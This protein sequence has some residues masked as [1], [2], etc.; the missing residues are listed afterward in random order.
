MRNTFMN[1]I[2]GT[3]ME[4]E[5]IY[6]VSG[7]AGLGVFDDFKEKLPD[8]FINMGVAEQNM[9][10]FSAGLAMTGFKV[11]LYN[12]TPFLIYRCYE[13]VRN[14]ICYQ[15]MPVV[16]V[17]IG[18]GLTYAPAG[19][20]HYSVEDIGVAQTL[21]NLIVLSPIDPVE[22]KL[23]AQYS[24]NS[25]APV[26]VRIPKNGEP[27]IHKDDNFDITR[28]CLI[29]DGEDISILFHGSI[30]IEVMKANQLLRKEGIFPRLISVP[31]VQPL[32]AEGLFRMLQ[33]S[34]HVLCVEEHFV[35]TGLGAI[36]T[37]EYIKEK[38]SWDFHLMGITDRFIHEIKDIHGM[39]EFFG[40]S[41]IK[42]SE[43]SK[44]LLC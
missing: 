19:M 17:G 31:M 10:S 34:R 3:C 28:P 38:P 32:D 6:I 11:Y 24:L 33:G 36:L 20:T 25:N 35:N 23:A 15:E 43:F 16:M 40:I 42:I 21:P 8:R 13:Q 37:R 27:V 14:D 5:D 44:G 30:S 41:G 26:L 18:S 22:A 29:E 12:I 9:A 4:R 7:D 2:M 1:T 39:R